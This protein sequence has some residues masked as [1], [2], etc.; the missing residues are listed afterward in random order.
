[1]DKTYIQLMR[2]KKRFIVITLSFAFLFYFMLP[3]GLIF[4]PDAMNQSSFITGVT[5][6]WLYAFLQILM[7]WIL[8]FFYHL[9]AKKIDRILENMTQ[10]EES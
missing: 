6:A 9:K 2:E 7:I 8:S 5:W 3:I 1:M 10:E 4:F